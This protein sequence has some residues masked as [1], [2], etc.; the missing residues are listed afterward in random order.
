MAYLQAGYMVKEGAS[1]KA[2]VHTDETRDNANAEND[3]IKQMATEEEMTAVACLGRLHLPSALACMGSLFQG[4]LPRLKATWQ[5]IGPVTPDIAGLLEETRNMVLHMG[6]LLTD[7]DECKGPKQPRIPPSI[8]WSCTVE[9]TLI[10]EIASLIEALMHLMEVQVTSISGTSHNPRSGATL[11]KSLLWFL[12]RWTPAYLYQDAGDKNMQ[13][14]NLKLFWAG[15]S[16]SAKQVVGFS[17]W[18]CMQ[19]ITYWTECSTFQ[20][21]IAGLLGAMAQHSHHMRAVIVQQPT[22]Q[23]IVLYH[24]I[25]VGIPTSSFSSQE[26]YETAVRTVMTKFPNASSTTDMVGV[27][28]Y[29]KLAQDEKSKM[30][31]ALLLVC[32]DESVD[33]ANAM[34]VELLKSVE[35]TFSSLVQDL[36]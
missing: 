16:E 10:S 20:C 17:I 32:C 25:T 2:I 11:G 30:L 3:E 21:D 22:F 33:A 18:L 19:Y 6:Y 5:E 31:T 36:S 35:S 24:C 4:V 34:F 27:R 8:E 7:G 14:S 15:Q 28:G 23:Q 9:P 1:G 12:T 29:H 26:Q 13:S